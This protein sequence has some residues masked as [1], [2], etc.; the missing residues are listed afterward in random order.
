MRAFCEA[1]GIPVNPC[2]KVVVAKDESEC[3]V[4]FELARRGERN[5]VELQLL[6]ESELAALEPNARTHKYALFS[7]TTATVN[8]I[9]VSRALEKKLRH[10]GVDF[11]FAHPFMRKVGE[12]SVEAGGR[13]FSAGKVINC[14]GLYADRIAQQY[15]FGLAYTMIPFKG[16]YLKYNAG[17]LPVRT[18]VYP[19]PNLKN[20]F[21]G[22]HF[23]VTAE[24][25]VKIGPTAIP[26]LWRENY[27]GFANFHASEMLQALRWESV[28]FI[29][30]AFGFRTLAFEEMR[31]YRRSYL[32]AQAAKLVHRLDPAGFSEWSTPGIRAQLLDTRDCTLI[33]DFLVEGD[34]R[35]LHVLNAVSPAFTCS[36][37]FAEWLAEKCVEGAG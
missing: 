9:Q 27:R 28:L 34:A 8:P 7:P 31:K 36:F 25:G 5:G 14:A 22:V 6:D 29:R 24:G 10:R 32:I 37:A 30:N 2:C 19:V 16:V 18:N 1:S 20:P 26:A 3:E 13:L 4:L 15:G 11:Y 17:T 33:Q 12:C 21:L 23:T 35:S